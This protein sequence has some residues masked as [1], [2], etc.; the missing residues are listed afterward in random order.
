MLGHDMQSPPPDAEELQRS[1][2]RAEA[3]R[4]Q[5]MMEVEW[6]AATL[7]QIIWPLSGCLK[8]RARRREVAGHWGAGLAGWWEQVRPRA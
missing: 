6:L 1:I 7:H 2:R 8:L 5:S 3:L 4:A